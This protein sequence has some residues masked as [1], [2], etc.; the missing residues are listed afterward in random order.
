[1]GMKN[2]QKQNNFIFR[3]LLLESRVRL[4]S[5]YKIFKWR[6][7]NRPLS[8]DTLSLARTQSKELQGKTKPNP[9]LSSRVW[10]T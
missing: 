1:M 8:R 2:K 6:P 10:L 4:W 5:P 3:L 7:F 9:N